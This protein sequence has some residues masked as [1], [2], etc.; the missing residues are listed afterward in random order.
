MIDEREKAKRTANQILVVLG[1]F[2]MAW[3]LVPLTP[4]D[5]GMDPHDPFTVVGMVT[6][7]AAGI[8]AV[9]DGMRAWFM[10]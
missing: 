7:F 1:L 2:L 9:V 6:F 5:E 10:D 4:W 3:A 8:V